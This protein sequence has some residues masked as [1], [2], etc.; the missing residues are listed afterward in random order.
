M[1]L[2]TK[3]PSLKNVYNKTATKSCNNVCVSS[4][5]SHLIY[6]YSDNIN[7]W[8]PS[9]QVSTSGYLSNL[10]SN[11]VTEKQMFKDSASTTDNAPNASLSSLQVLALS[12][13]VPY[14]LFC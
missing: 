6:C 13:F 11:L 8:L 14:L 3:Y 9:K 12:V 5:T 4:V 2:Y 7:S 1:F 10:V